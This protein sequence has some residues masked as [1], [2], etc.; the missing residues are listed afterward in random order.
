MTTLIIGGGSIGKIKPAQPA[1]S[2]HYNIVILTYLLII[3]I[4]ISSV[5]VLN[6]KTLS[7]IAMCYNNNTK[8]QYCP[9]LQTFF[10]LAPRSLLITRHFSTVSGYYIGQISKIVESNA[11]HSA[12][13]AS[14]L[15]TININVEQDYRTK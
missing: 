6:D 4:I 2:A 14:Q 13:F 11:F 3:I 5:V 9:V 10:T 7:S 15:L 8:K 1:F 12:D